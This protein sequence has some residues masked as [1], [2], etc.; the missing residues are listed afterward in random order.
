MYSQG[1]LA[2]LT[3][4]PPSVASSHSSGLSSAPLKVTPPSGPTITY[5]LS[6][7]D[8]QKFLLDAAT[9]DMTHTMQAL[10]TLSPS[11]PTQ[12]NPY[13]GIARALSQVTQSRS[14][15]QSQTSLPGATNV[16]SVK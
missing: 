10:S 12:P 8:I 5:N 1:V 16:P 11:Q 4:R 2:G 3:P 13:A 14:T 15:S 7:A 9:R 6:P